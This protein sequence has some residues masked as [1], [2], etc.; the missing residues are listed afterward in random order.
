V[1]GTPKVVE[2]AYTTLTRFCRQHGISGREKRRVWRIETE[3]AREMQH[4]TS[5]YFIEIGGKRVKRHCASLVFG[6]SRKMHIAFYPKFDRFHCK[7]FLTAAFR[8]LGGL[9]RNCVIDNSHVVIAC[10]TGKRAQV[11]PEMEAFEKRFGFRFWA[12]ELGDANRSGKVERVFHF[13]E[14]N[15][16]V[17]RIFKDD[18]DL[19]RQALEW[20]E[21]TADVR[22]IRELGASPREQASLFTEASIEWSADLARVDLRLPVIAI[23]FAPI[24][25]MMGS[26]L[27]I[28]SVSPLFDKASIRSFL[29]TRPRSPWSASAGWR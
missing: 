29:V 7:I 21:G 15:F 23:S 19:N 5:P 18:D 16:L 2:A 17:G 4:D 24:F 12:H 28:S 3:A 1:A 9:C 14:R 22:R 13:V 27:T 20:I 8:R 6:Y 26:S 11:S 10:G 25:F